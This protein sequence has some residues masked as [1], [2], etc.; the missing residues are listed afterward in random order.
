[1]V[2]VEAVEV[3]EE[4]EEEEAARGAE[5]DVAQQIIKMLLVIFARRKDNIANFCPEPESNSKR[6]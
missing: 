5:P 4:D 2:E 1:M 6:R 3:V